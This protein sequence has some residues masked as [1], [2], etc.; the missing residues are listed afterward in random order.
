MN[1]SSVT[2]LISLLERAQGQYFGEPV[3]QLEHALQC[4]HLA[5]LG[6]SD[7]EMVIAALVHDIGHL[8][9]AGD[10]NGSADHDH[11][12]A[13]YLR[14]FGFSDRVVDLVAGHVEAKR[15]LTAT[16]PDYHMRLSDVSKHSLME[17][18]GP[19]S[20]AEAELFQRDPLFTDKLK[21]R[22][23]DE[24]AKV[25]GMNADALDSYRTL[26]ERHLTR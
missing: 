2:Q 1:E 11:L 16:N 8:I 15:F 25:P 20:P 4:A 23:W 21:L 10:E 22:A 18:G 26:L 9:A 12:G 7:D 17:Q 19:M 5:R 3:T 13:D 6:G 14:D 24:G